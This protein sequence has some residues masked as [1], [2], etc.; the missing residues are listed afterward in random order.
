[1]SENPT[2]TGG[3]IAAEELDQMG[4]GVISEEEQKS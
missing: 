3:E 1:M 2:D 4:R